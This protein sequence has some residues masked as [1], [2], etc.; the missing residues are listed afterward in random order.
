MG[1]GYRLV[2]REDRLFRQ[3][4]QSHIGAP[5]H[6]VPMTPEERASHII[7]R[8]LLSDGYLK[9]EDLADEIYVSKS[10]LQNDLKLVKHR[11]AKYDIRLISRPHYGLKVSGREMKL[12]FCM[13]DT[14]FSRKDRWHLSRT[15]PCFP[16]PGKNWR[17][18]VISS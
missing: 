6:R 7:R 4:L 18:S 16:F 10:T 1:K 11:L 14:L 13:A 9:L 15:P 17:R 3:F 5:D 12:R 8:L 2:V